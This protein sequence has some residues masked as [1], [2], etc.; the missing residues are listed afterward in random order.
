[1]ALR[2]AQGCG[3]D[4]RKRSKKLRSFSMAGALGLEPKMAVLETAVI[5]SFT[6]P[7]YLSV[8]TYYIPKRILAIP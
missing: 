7:L 8:H 5:A 6:T 2:Q 3:Q 1:M 4:H